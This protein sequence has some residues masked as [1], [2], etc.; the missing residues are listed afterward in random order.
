M[1]MIERWGYADGEPCWVELMSADPRAAQRFYGAVFGW[2]F[3]RSDPKLRRP[4]REY[5]TCFQ[6]GL[7][8]AGIDH[9]SGR[10]SGSGL[11][12][13]Y[14]SS[15]NLDETARRV[16]LGGGK[17]VAGPLKIRGQGRW[18]GV[19][20]PAGAALR[21]WQSSGHSGS[22]LHAVPGALCWAELN[23]WQPAVADEFYQG[24]FGFQSRQVGDGVDHVIWSRTPNSYDK[25]TW[26][27][28]DDEL[29]RY[30]AV[31]VPVEDD[32]FDIFG[33]GDVAAE[34]D[35]DPIDVCGRLTMTGT[36]GEASPHWMVYFAVDDAEAAVEQVTA[37]GGTVCVA[38][39]DAP[40]GRVAVVADPDGA[41]F[42][43][44]DLSR[45]APGDGQSRR[46]A[47]G[48]VGVSSPASQ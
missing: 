39:F 35:D 25:A 22:Q 16:A 12:M 40:S 38:P 5:M 42:G 27:Q 19:V 48:R 7:R 3:G 6:D 8:V 4:A 33:G 20:D 32:D 28:T 46:Y 37:A 11:W 26:S 17:V 47:P 45:A 43:V 41:T 21:F 13:L 14:L 24:V 30:D 2:T 29:R 1:T 9:R 10:A 34:D 18:L 44:A 31:R 23:T 36:E 15:T